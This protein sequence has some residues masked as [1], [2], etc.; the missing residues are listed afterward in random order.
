M[1]D[2]ENL[3]TTIS[4]SGELVGGGFL[5]RVKKLKYAEN[6]SLGSF[7]GV[8]GCGDVALETEAPENGGGFLVGDASF[9]LEEGGVA[10]GAAEVGAIAV[11]VI[12]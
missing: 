3:R 8:L 2:D 1:A 6:H 7:E 9:G 4:L 12:D 10:E 5:V 11:L